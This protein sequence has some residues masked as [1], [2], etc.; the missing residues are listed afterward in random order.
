MIITVKEIHAILNSVWPDLQQIWCFDPEY[1]YPTRDEVK[2][3]VSENGINIGDI[4]AE[5]P[6]C[7]DYALQLHAKI[8]LY[9]NWSFGEVFANKIQGWSLLHSLNICCCQEG[10]VL[11]DPRTAHVWLADAEKDNS[12]WVRM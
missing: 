12:L 10:V 3:F 4:K 5:N 11:I 9:A 1:I 8:K 6:D 7:D 2:K